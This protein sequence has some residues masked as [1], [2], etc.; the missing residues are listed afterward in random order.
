MN[1]TWLWAVRDAPQEGPLLPG[2][3]QG[4]CMVPVS[5]S[6]AA[7]ASVQFPSIPTDYERVRAWPP[8]HAQDTVSSSSIGTCN[9]EGWGEMFTVVLGSISSSFCKM[10]SVLPSGQVMLCV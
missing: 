7:T 2:I 9:A 6:V 1:L 8:A 3:V 10:G 4:S 5:P